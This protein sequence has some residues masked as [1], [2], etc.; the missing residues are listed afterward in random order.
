MPSGC[1]VVDIRKVDPRPE[2]SFLVDT[3]AWY[4][5]TYTRATLPCLAIPRTRQLEQYQ[6]FVKRALDLGSIIGRCHLSFAELAHRIEQTEFKI[7]QHFHPA[8]ANLKLKQYRNIPEER[9]RVTTEISSVWKQVK[10]MS[11][12]CVLKLDDAAVDS[13]L[14][15]LKCSL[16]DGYDSLILEALKQDGMSAVLTDD[17]DYR[18]LSG[19]TLFTCNDAV[20]AEARRDGSLTD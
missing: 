7:F 15:T 19:I 6:R 11:Q 3:N 8:Q 20:I 1:K 2:D 17:G 14:K 18:S 4:W 5:M 16:L 9:N 13:A 12:S 10:E